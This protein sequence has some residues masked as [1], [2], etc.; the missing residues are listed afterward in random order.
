MAP[1]SRKY[2]QA[3][4]LAIC[5]H[6]EFSCSSPCYFVLQ[7]FCVD[8]QKNL[9]GNNWKLLG[10]RFAGSQRE[11]TDSQAPPAAVAPLGC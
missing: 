8:Q 5:L 6:L 11:F 3:S 1:S 4:S 2:V 7:I 10:N 9:L